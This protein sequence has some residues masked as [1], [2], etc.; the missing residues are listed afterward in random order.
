MSYKHANELIT[1]NFG[2]VLFTYFEKMKTALTETEQFRT[3]ITI[4]SPF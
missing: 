2:T 3:Q 1:W 4:P